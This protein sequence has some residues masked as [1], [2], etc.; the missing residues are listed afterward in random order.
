VTEFYLE[1]SPRTIGHLYDGIHLHTG[2]IVIL[3]S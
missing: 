3:K 1:C 2:V